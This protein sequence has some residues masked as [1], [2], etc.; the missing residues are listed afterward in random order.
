MYYV[1]SIR[2]KNVFFLHSYVLCRKETLLCEGH[3]SF[4]SPE[5]SPVGI[6]YPNY[7]RHLLA[8]AGQPVSVL[9]S[10]AWIG[11]DNHAIAFSVLFREI[12]ILGFFLVLT[13]FFDA[14]K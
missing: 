2:E 11:Q 1:T 5:E 8:Q 4:T 9:Y 10:I 14:F 3:R 12:V 6:F 7:L 13:D